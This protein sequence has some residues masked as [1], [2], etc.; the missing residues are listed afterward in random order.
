MEIIVDLKGLNVKEDVL[1][2]FA[3]TL[4]FPDWWGKNWDAFYDCLTD[5]D[6]N[7]FDKNTKIIIKNFETFKHNKLEFNKLIQA[8]SDAKRFNGD[9][10]IMQLS[11]QFT[12]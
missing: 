11:Y 3:K 2:A 1:E 10:K 4:K 6:F 5:P 9:N 12:K 8:F 7:N